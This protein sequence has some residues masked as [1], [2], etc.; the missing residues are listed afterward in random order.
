MRAARALHPVPA[1][2]RQGDQP[3]IPGARPGTA[4]SRPA[5]RH[6]AG[7]ANQHHPAGLQHVVIA[8][9][10][11]L[12]RVSRQCSG[13]R[14]AGGSGLSGRIVPVRHELI[15]VRQHDPVRAVQDR[16]SRSVKV[17]VVTSR[18][19]RSPPSAS[20][21]HFTPAESWAARVTPAWTVSSTGSSRNRT[22]D[23]IYGGPLST[24]YRFI[25]GPD[26]VAF[27]PGAIVP[28]LRY[29]P[30]HLIEAM[31]MLI[32][33]LV[34]LVCTLARAVTLRRPVAD[35]SVRRDLWIGVGP[36]GVVAGDLGH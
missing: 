24:G 4:P 8:G 11:R 1:A 25:A 29:L 28:N 36:G 3:S 27:G 7:I 13:L 32:L 9:H 16:A 30:A 23:L 22:D 35:S 19:D 10:E 15:A 12:L 21:C 5:P 2:L 14:L 33:G 31:P 18:R 6:Q 34:A 20:T 26:Q 17:W